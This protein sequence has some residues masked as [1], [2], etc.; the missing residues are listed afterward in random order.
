MNKE[1]ALMRYLKKNNIKL[2]DVFRGMMNA[3][4]NKTICY[5]T[6]WNIAHGYVEPSL[7]SMVA[8]AKVLKVEVKTII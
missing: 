3:E 8:I 2:I 7:R 5:K 6:L 4:G 1:T